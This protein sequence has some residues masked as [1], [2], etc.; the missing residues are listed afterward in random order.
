MKK[1][2][3]STDQKNNIFASNFR[4]E[5]KRT[6]HPDLS[7]LLTFSVSKVLLVVGIIVLLPVLVVQCMSTPGVPGSSTS[8]GSILKEKIDRSISERGTLG[9]DLKD[10]SYR[11]HSLESVEYTPSSVKL[12]ALYEEKKALP[13]WTRVLTG[14]DQVIREVVSAN[15]I[16]RQISIGNM[17]FDKD[18]QQIILENVRIM[19][20]ESMNPESP[21]SLAGKLVDAFEASR[22]FKN[23]KA[24]DLALKEQ[25]TSTGSGST[26]TPVNLQMEYQFEAE[27]NAKDKEYDLKK[28]LESLLQ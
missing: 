14:I 26:F 13:T 2:E 16:L 24:S 5:V 7:S 23:V 6:V 10:I 27:K 4:Q 12:T 18:T 11:V 22:Y 8:S 17:L 20:G 15:T 28:E 1:Q 3:Q 19:Q 21:V 25:I 9:T